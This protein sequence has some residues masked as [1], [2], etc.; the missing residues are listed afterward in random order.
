MIGIWLAGDFCHESDQEGSQEPDSEA[1]LQSPQQH[2]LG[3]SVI[4]DDDEEDDLV[5]D[6]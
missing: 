5:I 2:D 6:D 3:S 1:F 4:H